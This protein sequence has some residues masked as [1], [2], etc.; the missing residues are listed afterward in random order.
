MQLRATRW[1]GFVGSNVG[2]FAPPLTVPDPTGNA[3]RKGERA[4]VDPSNVRSAFAQLC[5]RAA[6]GHWTIHELRHTA[7]SLMLSAGVPLHIVS[8]VLGHSSISITKDVYGHL[9][10]DDRER[11]SD[12][13]SSVLYRTA[14]PS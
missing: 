3:D 2:F 7:A 13:I 9:V 4:P 1:D 5:Q 6:L 10:S 14:R 8:D 11:A 12:A